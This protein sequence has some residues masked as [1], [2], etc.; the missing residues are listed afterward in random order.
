MERDCDYYFSK[1]TA[2]AAWK[3]NDITTQNRMLVCVT[4][5][6]KEYWFRRVIY[7]GGCVAEWQLKELAENAFL[8]A[9]EKFNDA[10][11]A[12]KGNIK[13]P[14]Y[15]NLLYKIFKNTFLKLLEQEKKDRVAENIFSL[16]ESAENETSVHVKEDDLF[17]STQKVLGMINPNCA[18]LMQWRYKE[19]LS[20]DE[21][22]NRKG[23]K[24][25]SCIQSLW[26]C[27]EHFLELFRKTK[28]TAG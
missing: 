6:H 1:D 12:G 15:I 25:E 28:K 24:P 17:T 4:N 22:A 13:R 21:I 20:F 8:L 14:Q 11:K 3:N 19:R 16:G 18:E 27:K 2:I 5:Q 26:R 23:I 9:W 7:K 10:G